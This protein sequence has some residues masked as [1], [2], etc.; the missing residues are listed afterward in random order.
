M[1]TR[2][3]A[4]G[5]SLSSWETSLLKMCLRHI[6]QDDAPVP[7]PPIICADRDSWCGSVSR[8]YFMLDFL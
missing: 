4:D 8:P 7:Y 3:R 1:S 5:C 2:Q 6:R